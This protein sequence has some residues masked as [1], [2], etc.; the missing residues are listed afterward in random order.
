[1]ARKSKLTPELRL[2]LEND[3]VSGEYSKKQLA[4]KYG[5]SYVYICKVLREEKSIQTESPS[6][7]TLEITK[8][9]ENLA[10]QRNTLDLAIKTLDSEIKDWSKALEALN[11]GEKQ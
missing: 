4:I 11:I 10:K 2:Q 6:S 9:L 5:L 3:F 1:M 8:K 7:A